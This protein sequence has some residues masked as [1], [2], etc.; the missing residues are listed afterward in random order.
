[1]FFLNMFKNRIL[2]S[3][4]DGSKLIK[5]K[6]KNLDRKSTRFHDRLTLYI[7]NF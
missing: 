3:T 5:K 7:N 6:K 2:Q 1:M 4:H